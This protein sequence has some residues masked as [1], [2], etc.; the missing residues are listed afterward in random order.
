MRDR[1]IMRAFPPAESET[2]GITDDLHP[3]RIRHTK[4]VC[5]IGPSSSDENVLREMVE[6]GM[7]VVR[8]NFSHGEHADHQ[9]V[10]ERVRKIARELMR[11]MAI[12]ADL[13]GPKIRVGRMPGERLLETGDLL[14]LLTRDLPEPEDLA[15]DELPIKL[16]S[17]ARSVEPGSSIM[18]ADGSIKLRVR[19]V[20]IDSGR[21]G[22]LVEEGGA[23]STAKGVNL[24]DVELDIPSLTEKDIADLAF[25][26]SQDVDYIAQSFV[27][28]PDDVERLRQLIS[29]H[30]GPGGWRPQIISKIEK[31]QAVERLDDILAASDG[32]MVARGDLG[33]ELGAADVPLVQK[34][35]IRRA[36]ELGIPV[37]T[38]TQM[39][40]TMTYNPEPTR[41]EASDVANAVLDGTSAVMLSG[42][43]AVGA[44]PVLAI[45]VLDR[46]A[47]AVEPAVG[48]P[49]T[50]LDANR[51]RSVPQALAATA[52]EIG[53]LLDAAAI[54]VLTETGRSARQ[55]SRF[56]PRRP[57]IAAS[58][59]VHACRRLA[60]DWGT[61]PVL[62]GEIP[63]GGDP[64]W[65]DS[66]T[67]AKLSGL[68]AAGEQVVFT[69]G[70]IAGQ[71]GMTNML[72][73]EQFS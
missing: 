23:I 31:R 68:I 39:L 45:R 46:I 20:A 49:K 44:W 25:A 36:K 70:T 35:I 60:L 32:V 6:S 43:T 42:E 5:T 24:P 61:V 66:V 50:Y 51:T 33:V 53:E 56:R 16:E 11:P 69:A 28:S 30:V 62:I 67:G 48:A 72:K 59:D 37:I 3:R 34:R 27:R 26:I 4:I 17:L 22:C 19:D 1:S 21:I 47:R 64:I 54:V 41:A 10:V 7:N 2:M 63:E 55:V 58:R 13:Q 29:E 73:V 15:D 12:I 52:C 8:L 40:E 9:L 18:L 14:T 38:A 65:T 71:P 57:I